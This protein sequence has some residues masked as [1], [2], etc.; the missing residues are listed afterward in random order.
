MIGF[1]MSHLNDR[2]ESVYYSITERTGRSGAKGRS[3]LE[4]S[5]IFLAVRSTICADRCALHCRRSKE[6]YE[7]QK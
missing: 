4:R 2:H 5:D 6:Q 1:G 7:F 3:G